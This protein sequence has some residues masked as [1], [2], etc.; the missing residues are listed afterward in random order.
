MR[1]TISLKALVAIYA[2]G[3]IWIVAMAGGLLVLAQ[4]MLS[5]FET[6]GVDDALVQTLATMTLVI[7]FATA[8][9]AGVAFILRTTPD[10][11]PAPA[12]DRG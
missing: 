1:S 5:F 6:I 3:L 11:A 12:R 2:L 8:V 10:T 7:L 4:P 9:T